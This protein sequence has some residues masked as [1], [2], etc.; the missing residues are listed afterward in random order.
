MNLKRKLAFTRIGDTVEIQGIPYKVE[1]IRNSETYEGGIEPDTIRRHPERIRSKYLVSLRDKKT[2]R[3]KKTWFGEFISC[4]IIDGIVPTDHVKKRQEQRSITDEDLNFVVTHGH[5][6][7]SYGRLVFHLTRE[8]LLGHSKDVQ[9][10]LA[11]LHVVMHNNIIVTTY[12]N[13]K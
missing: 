7:E 4:E 9:D 3:L 10:K 1:S 12:Q 5:C 8:D 6:K 13:K 11:G 2:G